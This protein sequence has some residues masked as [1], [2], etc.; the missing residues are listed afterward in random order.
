V[1]DYANEDSGGDWQANV[2]RG[3]AE[4]KS[5]LAGLM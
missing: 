1:T 2:H 5:V 3:Q 4:F